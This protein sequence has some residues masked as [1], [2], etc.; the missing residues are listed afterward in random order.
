MNKRKSNTAGLRVTLAVKGRLAKDAQSD[1]LRFFS[2]I[3]TTIAT[4]ISI[5][6]VGIQMT[7]SMIKIRLKSV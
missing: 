6:T 3:P 7:Q 5:A 1:Q 4:Q 2:H